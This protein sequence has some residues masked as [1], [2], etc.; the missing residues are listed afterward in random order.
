MRVSYDVENL[1]GRLS[2]GLGLSLNHRIDGGFIL[3]FDDKCKIQI[4]FIDDRI[5][6]SSILG[7]LLPSRYRTQVFEDALKANFKY[8][9]FGALGY[10]DSQKLLILTLAYQTIPPVDHEFVKLTDGFIKKAIAWS[11]ALKGSNTRLLI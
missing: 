2:E 5:L 3:N 7:E 9:C 4:E 10:N 11:D 1:I 6:F 8:T